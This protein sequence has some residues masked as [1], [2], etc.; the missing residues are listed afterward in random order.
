MTEWRGRLAFAGLNPDRLRSLVAHHGGA[1]RL[2]RAIE[3][4]RCDL[5]SEVADRVAVPWAT[6]HARLQSLGVRLVFH[7]EADYPDGISRFPDAP[8]ALFVDGILPD[9]P[10][11]AVVGTRR[12]TAYG[13]EVA[14]GYG[15]A[16]ADAGVVLVSGLARGIDGAAH[17]G[18]ARAEGL[19]V[20]V[21]GS[22]IDVAYPREHRLLGRRLVELGG[23]LV[24]EYPPG[25]IPEPWRFPLRNRIIAGLSDAV[26]VVEA[27]VRGG[28]LITAAKALEYGVP[29]FA[30]PGDVDRETSVGCNLLIRD[31]AHPVLDGDDLVAELSLLVG[32]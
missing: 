32:R 7:G 10:A 9:G 17:R 6:R 5:P 8:D 25:T 30:V 15:A 3:Q 26:V 22:G 28:A 4:G 29:V 2:V 23:G 18:T 14:D 24:T 1:R 13:R 12:C 20:A 21:L 31:G 11:V 19:G 16:L 27:G